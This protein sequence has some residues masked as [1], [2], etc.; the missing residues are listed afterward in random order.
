MN[1]RIINREGIAP[2][3]RTW[4]QIEVAG[5]HPAALG[6]RRVTQV[7]DAEALRELERT[8]NAEAMAAGHPGLLI[9]ADHLSHD[10]GRPTEA[11]GWLRE[12]ESREGQ[13]WGQ[14]EWTDLGAAAARN[15][16]YKFFST[17]YD[18]GGL[19]DLGAGRVR[20]VRLAGL[21][22][23]NRPN[24]KGGRPI[25]NRKGD[26]S[27][28]QHPTQEDKR[29]MKTIADK[30]GLPA[31]ATEEQI[32]TAIG[33]IQNRAAEAEAE[34]ILNRH[35]KRIPE[36]TR[37]KWRERLIANRAQA[38]EILGELPEREAKPAEPAR[39][40][41]T[42]RAAAAV[43]GADRAHGSEPADLAGRQKAAALTIMNRQGC[44]FIRAW[45]IAKNENPEL[46]PERAA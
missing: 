3:A 17:E 24:N 44:T 2:L 30:L 43:P 33:A 35:E 14:V 32:V 31:E 6:P 39:E 13:L 18:A 41:I 38:E 4:H 1:A 19:R 7:I 45:D 23:T 25:T 11:M 42:N 21:A 22:L 26:Q 5:E 20:P 37:D 16:R 12:L 34:E 40:Q 29:T 15:G 28:E 10:L 9:D 8:F 27:P 46:F 36:G